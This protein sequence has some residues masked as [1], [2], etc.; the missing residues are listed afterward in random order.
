MGDHKKILSSSTEERFRRLFD[1]Q[2]DCVFHISGDGHFLDVNKTVTEILGYRREELIGKSL[3]ML[4][5]DES[6][7]DSFEKIR[8][9]QLGSKIENYRKNFIAKDGESIPFEI[10]VSGSLSEEGELIVQS[11]ARD[12]R[13][14]LETEKKLLHSQNLLNTL[15]ESAVDAIWMKD[16]N[17]RF[18]LVNSY[19]AN[20]LGM[21]PQQIIGRKGEEV[22]PKELYE[23][24]EE[25]DRQLLK[26]GKTMTN[27]YRMKIAGEERVFHTVKAP[28]RNADGRITGLIAIARDMTQEHT[29]TQQLLQAQ[30]M[31]AIGSLAGGIAHDFNN[32]LTSIIG[33]LSLGLLKLD[34]GDD[35]REYLTLAHDAA[36]DATRL[37]RQ[38]LQITR[39]EPASKSSI[40]LESLV[41]ELFALLQSTFDKRISLQKDIPADLWPINGDRSQINQILMNLCVNARDGLYERYGATFQNAPGNPWLSMNAENVTLSETAARGMRNAKP[42]QYVCITVSDNGVGMNKQTMERVFEPFFTTKPKESGTGLGLSMVYWIVANHGGWV[43]IESE[44]GIGTDIIIYFPRAEKAEE[45]KTDVMTLPKPAAI[46]HCTVLIVEDEENVRKLLHRILATSDFTIYEAANGLDAMQMIRDKAGELN[47]IVLDL[48][49]PEMSGQEVLYNMR[50][51]GLNIPTLVCSGYPG[52]INKEGLE[53]LGAQYFLSKPFTPVQ[54]LRKVY[55]I[56]ESCVSSAT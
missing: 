15:V 50:R 26:Y 3:R 43:S 41:D 39:R 18:T 9:L 44:P 16:R 1:A 48:I 10:T 4:V 6:I 56:L 12:L 23:A 25:E 31:E 36:N 38:L 7:E 42:G 30:K 27:E 55:D 32:V 5:P 51:D 45:R 52:E 33:N 35:I 11:I 19:F 37:I 53:E 34:E 20:I 28:L 24:N 13:E 46:G 49:M 40:H 8:Q 54:F 14:Q 17:L 47:L 21:S 22:L 2:T 29:L